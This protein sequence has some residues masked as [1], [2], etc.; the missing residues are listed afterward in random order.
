M[1]LFIPVFQVVEAVLSKESL[2]SGAEKK[3]SMEISLFCLFI[4]CVCTHT[5]FAIK[6]GSVIV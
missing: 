3:V 4:H 6:D 1:C 5:L 2:S